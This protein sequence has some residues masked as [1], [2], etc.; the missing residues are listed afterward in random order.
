[1]FKP[2]S[3]TV[4]VLLILLL[5]GCAAGPQ[6]TVLTVELGPPVYYRGDNGDLFVARYGSLSDRSLYFVKVIMPDR[7]EYTLPQIVSASG[8]RY[9]DEREIVWWTHKGTVRVD[10]RDE[11][12]EWMTKYSEL[13]EVREK[14]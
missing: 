2:I 6:K 7:Q 13:R 11:Q 14:N 10:V 9:T 8:V 4:V 3:T 5:W 12:G 1:M